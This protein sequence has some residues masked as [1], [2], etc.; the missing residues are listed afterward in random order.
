MTLDKALQSAHRL[1]NSY[2]TRLGPCLLAEDMNKGW[3]GFAF[4][5]VDGPAD[6]SWLVMVNKSCEG[7]VMFAVHSRPHPTLLRVFGAAGN[8]FGAPDVRHAEA[9]CTRRSSR[10]LS[11]GSTAS[12]AGAFIMTDN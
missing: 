4:D 7:M 9:T 5:I 2:G 12:R 11:K 10:K 3:W 1:A 6:W 8:G